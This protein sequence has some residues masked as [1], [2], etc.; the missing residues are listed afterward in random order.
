MEPNMYRGTGGECI[1]GS[2]GVMANQGCPGEGS[3]TRVWGWA[4]CWLQ[5]QGSWH[6]TTPPTC[7][8]VGPWYLAWPPFVALQLPISH[9]WAERLHRKPLP[10]R[11]SWYLLARV[12]ARWD[13]N[14]GGYIFP[15]AALKVV[16][17]VIHVP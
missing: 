14:W 13:P 9:R 8:V 12:G 7:T 17:H 16:D 2:V 10:W 1:D 15:E 3:D 6:S 4:T 5:R 11:R